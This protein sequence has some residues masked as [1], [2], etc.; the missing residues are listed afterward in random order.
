ME[1]KKLIP[2]SVYLSPE[3]HK[4]LKAAAKKRKASSMIRD[5]IEMILADNDAYKAGYNKAITDAAKVVFDCPE[6]QMVA[7]KGKDIGAI[8]SEQIKE[9]SQ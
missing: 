5:A 6:A 7:V 2:Y 3:H 8:L 9:L 4:K 1:A